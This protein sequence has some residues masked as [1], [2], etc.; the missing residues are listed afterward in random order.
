MKKAVVAA[1]AMASFAVGGAHAAINF[2]LAGASTGASA[3]ASSDGFAPDSTMNYQIN[4][5]SNFGDLVSGLIVQNQAS[6]VSGVGSSAISALDTETVTIAAISPSSGSIRFAGATSAGL[7]PEASG[8]ASAGSPGAI[9]YYK[10]SITNDPIWFTIDYATAGDNPAPLSYLG[11]LS[12][13]T[14]A[15][16]GL[17]HVGANDSGTASYHL[18]PGHYV[19][20]VLESASSYAPDYLSNS[21]PG[22]LLTGSSM[23]VFTFSD[24]VPEASTW[25]MMGLGFGAFALVAARRR[26]RPA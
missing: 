15:P 2:E 21:T 17:L 5:T 11:I 19:F 8:S 9:A 16:V 6:A 25:I 1:L 7:G 23:G 12:N 20:S 24:P 26:L 10:F 18:D 14:S 13:G 4:S 3:F 22:A